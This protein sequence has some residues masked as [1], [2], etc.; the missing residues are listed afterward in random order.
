MYIYLID[1]DKIIGK[2]KKNIPKNNIF[3][4]KYKNDYKVLKVDKVEKDSKI[5]ICHLARLGVNKNE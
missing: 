2:Y 3:V 1:M 5:L 4:Y